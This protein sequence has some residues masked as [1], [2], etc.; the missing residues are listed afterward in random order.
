MDIIAWILIGLGLAFLFGR[1]IRQ[2]ISRFFYTHTRHQPIY[3]LNKNAE[4][5]TNGES[6]LSKHMSELISLI[7][8]V[9]AL[10]IIISGSYGEGEQ[11]WA[12]GVIG[13]IIG[14]WLKPRKN[15]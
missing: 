6:F 15:V 5:R 13:T 2:W 3:K 10:Y 7:V 9:C 12:Y 11:K 1:G 14:Y 4:N 8:L